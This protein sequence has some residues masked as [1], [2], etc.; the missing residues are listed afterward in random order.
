MTEK[1]CTVPEMLDENKRDKDGNQKPLWKRFIQLEWLSSWR[2]EFM[3][4]TR[5]AELFPLLVFVLRSGV[6]WTLGHREQADRIL[7]ALHGPI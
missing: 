5:L 2:I 3:T 7:K 6:F 1:K 4:I